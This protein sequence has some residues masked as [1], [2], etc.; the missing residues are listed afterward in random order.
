MLVR[1]SSRIPHPRGLT[2]SQ[3]LSDL[4]ERGISLSLGP[5]DKSVLAASSDADPVEVEG[6]RT[7][8]AHRTREPWERRADPPA[9][10][11]GVSAP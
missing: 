7:T 11:R 8:G 2:G 1:P 4:L 10:G 9:A 3:K 5:L 6:V